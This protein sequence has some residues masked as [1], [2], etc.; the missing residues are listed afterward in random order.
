MCLHGSGPVAVRLAEMAIYR[1]CELAKTPDEKNQSQMRPPTTARRHRLLRKRRCAFCTSGLKASIGSMASTIG[2]VTSTMSG[3]KVTS[4]AAANAQQS[5]VCAASSACLPRPPRPPACRSAT[6]ARRRQLLWERALGGR[7]AS[8]P[9]LAAQ[10]RRGTTGDTAC[11]HL[12]PPPHHYSPNAHL[13]VCSSSCVDA[14]RATPAA[15]SQRCAS[16]R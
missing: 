13:P 3:L 6:G 2:E 7:P 1:E 16:G 10:L 14:R 5:S 8:L 12:T 9:P 4:E 15:Q 11:T